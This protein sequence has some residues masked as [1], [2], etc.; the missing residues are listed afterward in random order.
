GFGTYQLTQWHGQRNSAAAAFL[1]PAMSRPN[2]TVRT[3]VQAFEILFQGKRAALVSFQDLS[4]SMQER[5]QREIVV[6]AGAIGSPQLLIFSG[7]GPG[8]HL[9]PLDI[10]LLPALP[11]VGAT[12]QPHPAVPVAYECRQPIS[13][14]SAESIANLIR[15]MAFKSGPL[16]SN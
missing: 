6:C 3:S 9:R 7:I 2:L 1:R 13:L 4:G 11:G 16:T 5:A 8:D 12:Q 10:P 14:A 15:Y